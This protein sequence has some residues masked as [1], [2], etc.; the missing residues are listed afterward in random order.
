MLSFASGILIGFLLGV[1]GTLLLLLVIS[2]VPDEYPLAVSASKK[3]MATVMVLILTVLG[4]YIFNTLNLR[5]ATFAT[6]TLLLLV[7]GTARAT[8]LLPS[9]L[10]LA[11]A[12]VMLSYLLPPTGTLQISSIDD[13][14]LLVFFLFCGLIGTRLLSHRSEA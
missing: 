10:T 14:I 6:L 11:L 3:W 9:W 13:K 12:A 4:G 2:A 8:G 1:G 7:F 5:R